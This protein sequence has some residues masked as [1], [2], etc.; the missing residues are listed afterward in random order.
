V[1]HSGCS[2]C[3]TRLIDPPNV[4]CWCS[5]WT[6]GCANPLARVGVVC[7]RSEVEGA[8]QMKMSGQ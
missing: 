2:V 1:M 5:R 7:T 4:V 6:S 8:V 3:D